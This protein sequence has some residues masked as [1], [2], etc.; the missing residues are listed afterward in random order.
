MNRLGLLLTMVA[1]P[2]LAGCGTAPAVPEWKDG[3]AL[4]ASPSVSASQPASDPQAGSAAGSPL[5]AETAPGSSADSAAAGSAQSGALSGAAQSGAAPSG[6][7]AAPGPDSARNQA[8]RRPADDAR[9]AE[10]FT[11]AVQGRLPG[12]AVDRRPEEITALGNAACA[13]LQTGQKRGAAADEVAGYGV[14]GTEAREL[15]RLA[16]TY[17]CPA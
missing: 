15:V 1:V 4:P 13:E 14:S 8:A 10:R 17:L 12:V 16:R 2:V 7:A 9:A 3:V 5:P 6:A 11:S